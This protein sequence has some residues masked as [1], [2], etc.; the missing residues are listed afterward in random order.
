MIKIKH[1]DPIKSPLRFLDLNGEY[2]DFDSLTE[3]EQLRKLAECLGFL[4][5]KTLTREELKE[6]YN[7]E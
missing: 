5:C 3:E 7:I 1:I 6:Q 2:L 4:E